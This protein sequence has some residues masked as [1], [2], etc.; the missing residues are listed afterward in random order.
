DNMLSLGYYDVAQSDVKVN[1]SF[2][3]ML[4]DYEMP[5]MFVSPDSS[6]YDLITLTHELGHYL[7][8]SVYPVSSWYSAT[9]LDVAEI[10]S[11]G[12]QLLMSDKYRDIVGT[13]NEGPMQR[14]VY[15]QSMYA[16]ISGCL[17]DEFQQRAYALGEPTAD[18]IENIFADVMQSYGLAE[19]SNMH[20]TD[21]S[22]NFDQPYYYISYSVSAASAWELWLMARE[23]SSAAANAYLRTVVAGYGRTRAATLQV[24]GLGDPMDASFALNLCRRMDAWFDYGS[25]FIDI[26]SHWALD[27]I[28]KADELDLFNGSGSYEFKPDDTM[29][30]AMFVTVLGRMFAS[31]DPVGTSDYTDVSP[32]DY[33]AQWVCWANGAGVV[34]GYEDGT[35]RPHEPVTRQEMAVMMS[36][37]CAWA[38]IDLA[39]GE[40]DFTDGESVAVWA[41]DSV[42]S[43]TGA[44]VLTGRDDGGF[45]PLDTASR[46]EAAAAFVRLSELVK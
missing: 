34:T 5:Y 13:V 6:P 27:V 9:P 28:K 17:Y 31:D 24:S 39:S 4:T 19:R 10:H 43:L 11:T 38:G 46:A 18:E 25:Q 22:H 33:F 35:F 32:E 37:A 44:G 30:R 21:V 8:Y 20:W 41:A 12:L 26:G 3:T 2:T 42:S 14:Y 1:S 29:T 40:S 36:R 45:Y 7:H 23:D 15:F 16:L